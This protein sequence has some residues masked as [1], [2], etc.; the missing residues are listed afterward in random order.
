MNNKVVLSTVPHLLSQAKAKKQSQRVSLR[1]ILIVPFVLQ[2]FTAV[3]LTGYLSLRN[4]QRAIN[5]LA[6]KMRNEV[7]DRIDQHL[8]SYLDIPHKVAQTSTNA[9]DTGGIDLEN[10]AQVEQFLWR[11]LKTFDIDYILLGYEQGDYTA[12]GYFYGDERITFDIVSPA[13]QDGSNHVLFWEADSQGSRTRVIEDGG[14][15]V[16]QQEGWYAEATEAKTGV[17]SPVYNWLVEP[18]NL[19]IAFSQPI[20]D[21]NNNRIAVL[22]AEQHLAQISSFLQDLRVSASGQVFIIERN[23]LFIGSSADEKPYRLVNDTPERLLA[24][25]SQDPLIRATAQHLTSQF[26]D[27]SAI[28]EATQLSFFLNGKKQFVQVTPWKSEQGLD[29]LVVVAVPEADF[30]GQIQ[31]NT[32][33]T[34]MLCL[35]ALGIATLLGVLTARWIIR[36]VLRLNQASR[37]IAAGKFDQVVREDSAVAELSDLAM[38]FNQMAKQLQDSFIALEK[39]NQ[40]LEISNTELENRVRQRTQELSEALMHLQ[41]TQAQLIQTEK[42]S[43]LGQMVAG[44]AHE[45]NNPVSFIYGNIPHAREYIND[46]L[47]LLILYQQSYPQS[48]PT[49]QAKAEA[50]DLPFLVEDMPK[51]LDSMAVGSE[52]IYEIIQSLRTFSHLGKSEVK[53]LDIHEGIECTLKLLQNRLRAKPPQAEIQV[54]KQYGRIPLVECHVGQINQV[55]MNLLS[56]AI[57]ALNEIRQQENTRPAITLTTRVTQQG[58]VIISV[59]DNGSGIDTKIRNRLFDPFFTT[60]DVGKGTGLGLAISHQII[61]QD[62]QGKLYFES[63]PGQ[64]T[65]FFIEIPLQKSSPKETAPDQ[66]SP[67]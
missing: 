55:F 3:G 14:P 17:W 49:I 27:L 16:A 18:Y 44:L 34:V 1:L 51:L 31:Q 7:S 66:S 48:V 42:M 26:A 60:K 28:E 65:V 50:I 58:T 29:W 41:Q 2:I 59:A 38:S 56:N 9:I 37:A 23:G 52:R 12:T 39:A 61:T 19:A 67:D 5:G 20:Y 10:Q 64:G 43:S 4:G 22:A 8:N 6:S 33:A 45:I 32:Q 25:D 40:A 63:Q 62:H 53:T 46:L 35:V 15:F 21:A 36:P 57:D 11:Q 24:T 13:T 30:M 54:I 47:A